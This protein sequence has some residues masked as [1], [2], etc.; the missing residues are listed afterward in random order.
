MRTSKDR[1]SFKS[2]ACAGADQGRFGGLGR[3]LLIKKMR[4]YNTLTWP[5]I[6]G[7]PI[8]E[9][10]NFKDFLGLDSY[11]PPSEVAFGSPLLEPPSLKSG[12]RPSFVETSIQEI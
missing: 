2:F 4:H 12:I 11:G 7:N 10:L 5:Q 3:I 1:C 8:S 6:A 9:N